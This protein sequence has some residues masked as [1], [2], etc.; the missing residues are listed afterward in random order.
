[1]V[2]PCLNALTIGT[3]NEQSLNASLKKRLEREY[4]DWPQSLNVDLLWERWD[5]N[6]DTLKAPIQWRLKL[7]FEKSS[8]EI[9]VQFPMDYPFNPPHYYVNIKTGDSSTLI[10]L[11]QFLSEYVDKGTLEYEHIHQLE[12]FKFIGLQNFSPAVTVS[13]YVE[14]LMKDPIIMKVLKKQHTKNCHVDQ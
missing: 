8:C 1:M 2:L 12:R 6:S 14:G 5:N 4:A 9:V 3:K 10:E 7:P 11:K 13:G